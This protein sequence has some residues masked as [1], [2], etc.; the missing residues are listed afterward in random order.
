MTDNEKRAHELAIAVMQLKATFLRE[1]CAKANKTINFDFLQFYQEVY[2][3][4]LARISEKNSN[5]E[6]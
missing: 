3:D 4:A 6:D 5:K 1:D 2:D